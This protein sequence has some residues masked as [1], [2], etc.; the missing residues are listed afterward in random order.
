MSVKSKLECISGL[1]QV[2]AAIG[3][4]SQVS[5]VGNFYFLSGQVPLDPATGKIVEGGIEAQAEQVMKNLSNVLKGCGLSFSNVAKTTILLSSMESF[6]T[7]NTVYAKWLGEHRP[8]RA[9]FAVLGLPAGAM[10][11]IE[12]IAC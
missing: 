9:T 3:P 6:A 4:Y 8:A 2:P 1:D 11:E 7:M 5:K 12:M 10:V